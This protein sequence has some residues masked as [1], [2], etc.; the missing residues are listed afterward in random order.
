MSPKEFRLMVRKGEY[1][2][3]TPGVCGGFVQANLLGIP[4]EFFPDALDFCRKNPAP[5]PIIDV[6]PPGR[7]G[8]VRVAEGADLHTDLPGYDVFVEGKHEK[9]VTDISFLREK[10]LG[11]ILL[12]CSFSFEW[13]LLEEGIPVRHIEL[14]R[15]VPMYRTTIPLVPS[16]PFRG[17]MVVSMRPIPASLVAKAVLVTS[18]YPLA[19]GAPVH[20]GY[21]E[22]IG[23]SDLSSPDFG[24]PVPLLEGEIP[25]FWA[26]GV[27][28]RVVIEE[29]RIPLAVTHRPGHMF[30][31]DLSDEEIRDVNSLLPEG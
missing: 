2:G 9:R 15:N 16:G 4:E 17:N 24:D 3:P 27:T 30:V 8:R 18:R 20:V 12:G 6:S 14:S 13:A 25:L 7:G 19:H 31:T 10:N 26:C 11:F 29:S 5:C 28:P 21:P 23:I 22:G 1:A